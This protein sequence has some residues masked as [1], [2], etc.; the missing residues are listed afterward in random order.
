[1]SALEDKSDESGNMF[2]GFKHRRR[3]IEKALSFFNRLW[4]C[5]VA[6]QKM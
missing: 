2:L 3:K 6:V 5:V 4:L 1:M